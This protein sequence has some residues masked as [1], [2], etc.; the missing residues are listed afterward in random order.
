MNIYFILATKNVFY[1]CSFDPKIFLSVYKRQLTK[2]FYSLI[3]LASCSKTP[4]FFLQVL[5]TFKESF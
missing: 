2:L 3:N 1:E 5:E 4:S